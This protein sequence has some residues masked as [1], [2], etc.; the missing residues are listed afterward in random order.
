MAP[1]AL[2][3]LGMA[4]S[5]PACSREKSAGSP[6]AVITDTGE[7]EAAFD[8]A[9]VPEDDDIAAPCG[10]NFAVEY[11]PADDGLG[12]CNR[13]LV[14]LSKALPVFLPLNT[15]F[16]LICVA[17]KLAQLPFGEGEIVSD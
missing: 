8:A 9:A 2:A 6:D 4:P 15:V 13:S 1:Q 5:R 17:T 16:G 12:L 10:G 7:F 3:S 11:D 14:H